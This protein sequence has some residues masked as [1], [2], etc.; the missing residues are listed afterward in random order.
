[1]ESSAEKNNHRLK[2][3]GPDS[4]KTAFQILPFFA[5]RPFLFSFLIALS[6]LLL[7]LL[8]FSPHFQYNDDV[9][10]LLLLKGVGLTQS[11]SALNAREN[12][13][14][15]T[16]LKDLYLHFPRVQWYSWL[17]LGTQFLS[18]L[19]TLAALQWG[20][21]RGPRT[22]LFL[23]AFAGI[24]A[25]F[26][27]N[28]QWT[29]TASLAALGA[30]FLLAALWKEKA[31]K[32]PL[33]AY[34]LVFLLVTL[35]AQIRYPSLF[36]ITVLSLPVV[37]AL[38]W[39]KEITPSRRSLLLF[40]VLT[41]L[42][43]F[44]SIFYNHLYYQGALG[45]PAFIDFFDQHFE[46]HETRD[47]VYDQ[48]SKPLFDSIGWTANNLNLFQEWYFMDEDTLQLRELAEIE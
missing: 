23:F 17:L 36:L 25:Y 4:S 33:V 8:F 3:E 1:M 7:T 47:P 31:R 26:F 42:T 13:L 2:T 30:F 10:V 12:I 9:Q 39:K 34:F 24:G 38:A 41:F 21:I 40:L 48:D 46:L 44:S 16:L 19:A 22:W 18:L 6:Y 28:L 14:L 32:P 11:P 20:A 29:M 27:T 43:A 35:S 45:W 5:D 37:W 15:C